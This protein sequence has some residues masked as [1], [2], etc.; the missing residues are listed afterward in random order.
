MSSLSWW[1]IQGG[2]LNTALM[3]LIILYEIVDE[4]NELV[5]ARNR[6]FYGSAATIASVLSTSAN[7]GN[8]RSTELR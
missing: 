2:L 3:I 1:C 5:R 4:V 8:T 6:P 7:F